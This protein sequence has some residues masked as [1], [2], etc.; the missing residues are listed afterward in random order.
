MLPSLKFFSLA[1]AIDLDILP[2]T[3]SEELN[4]ISQCGLKEVNANCVEL[5]REITMEKIQI[6]I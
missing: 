3:A 4:A 2:C 6:L 5:K 1:K